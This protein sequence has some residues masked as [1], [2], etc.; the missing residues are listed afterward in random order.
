ML[1]AE[2]AIYAAFSILLSAVFGSTV[3]YGVFRL[4]SSQAD[5][6]VFS[7]PYISLVVII[8]IVTVVCLTVPIITY[9]SISRATIIERL[10]EAE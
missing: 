3:T 5:Y 10:R 6:A 7:F 1:T 9:R 8:F 2:G 4:F